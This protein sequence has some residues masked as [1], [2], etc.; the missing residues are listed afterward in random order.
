[1]ADFPKRISAESALELIEAGLE[2]EG[3]PLDR[4]KDKDKLLG[5][6]KELGFE[7]D[8]P[9][10]NRAEAHFSD[11]TQSSS[12]SSSHITNEKTDRM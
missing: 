10:W 1:M 8:G 7:V 3:F 4:R 5:A 9:Y 6:R 2:K 12:P 11:T